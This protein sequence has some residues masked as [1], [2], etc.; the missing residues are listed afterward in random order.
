[1]FLAYL[2]VKNLFQKEGFDGVKTRSKFSCLGI[3]TFKCMCGLY[4]M[5]CLRAPTADGISTVLQEG[6]SGFDDA[7]NEVEILMLRHL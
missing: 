2:K 1:L 6:D 4:P 3:G 5:L 7:K